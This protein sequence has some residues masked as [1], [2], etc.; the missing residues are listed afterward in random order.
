MPTKT[1]NV[2][3]SYQYWSNEYGNGF[4][5]RGIEA[6]S[7]SDAIN[8]ARRKADRDGHIGQGLG[9]VTFKATEVKD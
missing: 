9:R 7:K 4:T 2:A 1:Y 5:Y 3:V 6:D 8:Q